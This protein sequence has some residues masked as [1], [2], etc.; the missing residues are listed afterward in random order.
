MVVF[1]ALIFSLYFIKSFA[2]ESETDPSEATSTEPADGFSLL[3]PGRKFYLAQTTMRRLHDTTYRC[4]TTDVVDRS[5][6]AHTVMLTVGYQLVPQDQWLGFSQNFQFYQLAN[7][8][9]KMKSTGTEGPPTATYI[10]LSW[11]PSCVIVEVE[12]FILH[13][14]ETD[15][16]EERGAGNKAQQQQKAQCMLWRMVDQVDTAYDDCLVKFRQLCINQDVRQGFS[17]T[18][19]QNRTVGIVSEVESPTAES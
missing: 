13:D 5:E 4:I 10:F 12:H 1:G 3:D 7:G 11:D 17:R 16:P 8:Y 14:I 19:C 9:N 15:V 18:N 6:T 2:A